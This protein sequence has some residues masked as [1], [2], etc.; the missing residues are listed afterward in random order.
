MVQG[1][2]KANTGI[3]LTNRDKTAKK[4]EAH[5]TRKHGQS[6]THVNAA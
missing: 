5:T 4:A 6:S 2:T 3:P 1:V